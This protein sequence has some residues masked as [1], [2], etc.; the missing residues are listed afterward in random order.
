MSQPALSHENTEQMLDLR[1]GFRIGGFALMLQKQC[2]A[3]LV[4]CGQVCAIPDTPDWF[5][6]FINHQ[7]EAVPVYDIASC[8]G[9]KQETT[10]ERWLLLLDK[11]PNTAAL[12]LNQT[13]Q[14]LTN[15]ARIDPADYVPL[16][17]QLKRFCSDQYQHTDLLWLEFDHRAFLTAQKAAFITK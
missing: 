10:K 16:P 3:E 7:G 15:P 4:R 11:Q 9:Q 17:D 13:P 5:T 14:T 1:H 2:H 8:L 6:G 12:L